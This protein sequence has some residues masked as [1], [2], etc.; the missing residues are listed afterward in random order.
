[1]KGSEVLVKIAKQQD[2]YWPRVTRTKQKPPYIAVDYE[3]WKEESS[4]SDEEE[5][6]SNSNTTVSMD[7]LLVLFRIQSLTFG[8]D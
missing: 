5:D 4:S 2:I 8:M 7:I 1:M 3:R 6:K